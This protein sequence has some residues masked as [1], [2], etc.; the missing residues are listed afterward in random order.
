MYRY[1]PTSLPA[2]Q[3]RCWRRAVTTAL[4]APCTSS[5]AV[6]TAAAAL[7]PAGGAHAGNVKI[8]RDRS[9][10]KDAPWHGAPCLLPLAADQAISSAATR[11]AVALMPSA[12]QSCS[13]LVPGLPAASLPPGVK[14]PLRVCSKNS[15][16]SFGSSATAS[17]RHD[18]S[19]AL[20]LGLS[21]GGLGCWQATPAAGTTGGAGL[22]R[23]GTTPAS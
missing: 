15:C 1:H 18:R 10:G 23:Q 21:E 9:A 7:A 22:A 4:A 20:L 12:Q 6:G 3:C 17:V 19:A 8:C 11:C 5:D 16:S 2:T 14:L 13:C